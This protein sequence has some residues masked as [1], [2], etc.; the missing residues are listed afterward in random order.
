MY[1][2]FVVDGHDDYDHAAAGQKVPGY[3]VL[4][5]VCLCK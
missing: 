2:V 1:R 4:L 3:L 5:V